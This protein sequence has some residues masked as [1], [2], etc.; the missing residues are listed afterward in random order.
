MQIGIP[1]ET[2]PEEYRVAVTP[3]VVT[4][5]IQLGFTVKL[6]TNA[7]HAASFSDKAYT[8]SGATIA[9]S[10]NEIWESSDILLKVRAPSEHPDL[11]LHETSLLS[12]EQ[13]LICFIWPGQNPD[14]VSLLSD[15]GAYVLA[16]DAVPRISRAQKFDALSSMANVAGYRAIIESAGEFGRF[17]AGQITAAG[18][19]PP[20]RVLV[21]GAGVAGLAAI[22]AAGSMGANVRAF[23]TRPEVKEQV[24]S[25]LLYTSPSPR[26]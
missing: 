1:R 13:V 6:E 14:L 8:E 25:C 9:T 23:D 20:A 22:G 7:G 11:G 18:K 12:A 3:E 19:V 5:L 4:H 10:P 17:F 26:D 2:Y 24:E 21:I 15:S 16:M